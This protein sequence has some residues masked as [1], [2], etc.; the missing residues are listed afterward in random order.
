MSSGVKAG[1]EREPPFVSLRYPSSTSPVHHQ[2]DEDIIFIANSSDY[3][4]IDTATLKICFRKGV[5]HELAAGT[6]AVL[7][8]TKETLKTG[9]S[10]D[11]FG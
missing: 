5:D 8:K 4:S 11:Q 3:Q 6:N 1:R 10:K 9:T 2:R 7:S